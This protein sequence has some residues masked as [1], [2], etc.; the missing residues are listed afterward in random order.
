MVSNGGF[1]TSVIDKKLNS[2]SLN[3]NT[4]AEKCVWSG[5]YLYCAIPEGNVSG[6]MDSWYKGS[7][8]TT[9]NIRMIDT[10]NIFYKNVASLSTEAREEIDVENM[11]ISKDGSHLIFRNKK[12]GFLWML[13]VETQ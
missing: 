11:S 1:S 9:D 2:V 4:L 6:Y 10:E 12:D 3:T 5:V 13:R 8:S 7:V